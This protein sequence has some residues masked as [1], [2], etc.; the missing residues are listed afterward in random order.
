M[1]DKQHYAGLTDDELLHLVTLQ[2]DLY[3]EARREY[4]WRLIA[5]FPFKVDDIIRNGNGERAKVWIVYVMHSEVHWRA[6]KQKKDGTFGH[7]IVE[8]YTRGWRNPELV[9]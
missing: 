8:S 1:P 5:A 2:W 4:E 3:H 7:R 9:T 6:I